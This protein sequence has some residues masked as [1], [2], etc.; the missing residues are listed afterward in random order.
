LKKTY[1]LAAH[2]LRALAPGR[3]SCIASDMIVVDGA[4]VGFMYREEPDSELDS[5]WRFFAGAETQ[6]YAD[7]PSNFALYDIN[8][9]ANYDPDVVPLL[10]APVGSAFERNA[11]GALVATTAP[12]DPDAS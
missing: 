11:L 4:G 2:E 1:R 3:G 12:E 6:A 8:T 5:G 9:V 10:D 7:E